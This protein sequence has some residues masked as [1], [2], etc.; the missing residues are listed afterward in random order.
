MLW[1]KKPPATAIPNKQKKKRVSGSSSPVQT[2]LKKLPTV[3]YENFPSLAVAGHP[4]ALILLTPA[5]I[6]LTSKGIKKR[7]EKVNWFIRS[8][9]NLKQWPWRRSKRRRR[10]RSSLCRIVSSVLYS[11]ALNTSKRMRSKHLYLS[12]SW[13]SPYWLYWIY[14]DIVSVYSQFKNKFCYTFFLKK[15]NNAYWFRYQGFELIRQTEPRVYVKYQELAM[16]K[17]RKG[18]WENILQGMHSNWIVVIWG[19]LQGK[20]AFLKIWFSI[21]CCLFHCFLKQ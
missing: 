15:K 8:S 6:S 19:S 2:E 17:N 4:F 12:L 5:L 18:T 11:P 16:N 13:I 7:R 14:L 1:F 21:S 9:V 3:I 10:R 20:F